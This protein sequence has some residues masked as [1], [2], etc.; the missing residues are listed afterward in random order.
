MTL[1]RAEFAL[2][3]ARVVGDIDVTRRIM[4]EGHQRYELALPSGRVSV[5]VADLPPQIM[6]GLVKLPRC[7][8]VIE[9]DE[10]PLDERRSFINRFDKAFQRGGG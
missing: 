9:F 5:T 2:S 1:S 7:R 4:G 6:G 8:V 10:A 3:F